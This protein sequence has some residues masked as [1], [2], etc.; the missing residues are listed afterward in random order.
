MS[1][2]Q[3]MALVAGAASGIGAAVAARLHADGLAVMCADLDLEGARATAAR[4][5]GARSVAL[6]VR[7]E[8]AWAAAIEYVGR[9]DVLVNCVGITAASPLADTSFEEWRRVLGTNLDGAFLATK[10]GIRA[11][12]EGGGV[13]V[14]V[15]SASGIR[16]AAGAAA[17]ST[18]KAA[19]R[20]LVQTS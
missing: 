7:E 15:G 12:R 20:M 18:S 11:M 10:H 3:R 1:E 6:E 2:R 16:P 13:V 9:L 4:L 17:Y 8:R 19:L 14:H 5:P